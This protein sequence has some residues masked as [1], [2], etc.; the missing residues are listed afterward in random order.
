MSLIEPDPVSGAPWPSAGWAARVQLYV[1]LGTYAPESAFPFHVTATLPRD[2][3]PDSVRTTAPVELFLRVKDHEAAGFDNRQVP[4]Q[5][6]FADRA[7]AVAGV[8]E[9]IV[10]R[11]ETA[12]GTA[13]TWTRCSRSR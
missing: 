5:Y 6:R 1:P 8:L 10:V 12:P 13:L 11:A 3:A 4:F 9:S 7:S 2:D